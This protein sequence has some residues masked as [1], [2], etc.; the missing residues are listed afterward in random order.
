MSANC[1]AH[2]RLPGAQV[3]ERQLRGV[4]QAAVLH[5]QAQQRCRVRHA[6]CH[7]CPWVLPLI[8]AQQ[9]HTTTVAQESHSH[10]VIDRQWTLLLG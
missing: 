7:A 6:A 1:T 5:V 4:L 8:H 9:D 10:V 3:A 2:L